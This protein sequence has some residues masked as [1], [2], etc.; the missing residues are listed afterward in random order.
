MS[1]Y[2]HNR[3]R[4][5]HNAKQAIMLK[6]AGSKFRIDSLKVIIVTYCLKG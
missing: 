5:S 2:K 3:C 4:V 6:S 1:R